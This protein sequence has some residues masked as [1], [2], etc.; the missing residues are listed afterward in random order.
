MIVFISNFLNHHQVNICNEL[1]KYSEFYFVSSMSTPNEQLHLG[2]SDMN[3][4][5]E[6]AVR[7]YESDEQKKLAQKLL[8]EAEVV[9]AGSC[10]FPFEMLIP[11]LNAD[12]L[13]FWF[14]ERLFKYSWLELFY[15]PKLKRVLSQCTKYRKNKNF[16]LLCAGG[17]VASDYKW[18]NA[19]KGKSFSWGYFPP[20]I[21]KTD[22]EL[23]ASK[24]NN[25]IN[26]L[27]VAR[28]LSLKRPEHAISVAKTL[29][30]VGVSFE[31]KM[32]GV[33]E[34]FNTIAQMIKKNNLS[35]CVIQVGSVPHP[36]VRE[37]MDAADIFL[38]TSTR[39]E[40]WG[41]VLNESMNSGCAVVADKRIG[42]AKT[43]IKNGEN[44]IL[45]ASKKQLIQSVLS[46][47]RNRE[48]IRLLGKNAYQT[49]A[50][51]WTASVAAERFYKVISNLL[52]AEEITE[53][54]SGPM[55]KQ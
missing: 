6:Y 27:W 29:K 50:D 23:F 4:E 41:A 22:E 36:K 3:T 25:K 38:F 28:Y 7:M 47:V 13:T 33:G 20:V 46:L 45:F 37:Y 54:Y 24:P 9:I 42:G 35:D 10:T 1:R 14:S 51:E 52:R 16:Y 44:G 11:R 2:Y 32:I 26:I 18:Y 53:Y 15:P 34:K 31:L 49:I 40:G 5:C 39:R 43:M 17:F 55:V 12:K 8:N 30:K 48:R 21:I 19:F